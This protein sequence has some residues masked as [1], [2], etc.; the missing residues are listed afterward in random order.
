MEI[1]ALKIGDSDPAPFFNVVAKPNNWARSVGFASRETGTGNMIESHRI[2]LNYWAWFSEFLKA[3]DS[4]FAIRRPI[5]DH[6][7]NFPIGRSGFTISATISTTKKRVGVELHL[8]NDPL[9]S[10]IGQLAIEQ[11]AIEKEF[12]ERLDWQELPN[13][14]ASRIAIYLPNVDPSDQIQ[15]NSLQTWMLDRMQRF[16]KVF[17]S[18]VKLLNL[19]GHPTEEDVEE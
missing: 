12:G 17:S 15:I 7:V 4:S 5:R 8:Y 9:K 2:R 18:R 14:K 19:N 16:R 6:W 1:E 10:V 13:K 3:N 11:D